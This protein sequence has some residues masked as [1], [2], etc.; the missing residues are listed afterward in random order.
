M[1]GSCRTIDVQGTRGIRTVAILPPQHIRDG[2]SKLQSGDIVWFV[3]ALNRRIPDEIVDHLGIIKIHNNKVYL[4]HASGT[5]NNHSNSAHSSS[6][7]RYPASGG[8]KKVLLD[9]YIS[10]MPFIGILVTRF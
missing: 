10:K 5:K 3:K 2:I 9:H 4:L 1:A 6:T 8:V 7:G